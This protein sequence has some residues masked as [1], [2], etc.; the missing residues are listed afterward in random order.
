MSMLVSNP[1][2]EILPHFFSSGVH[3]RG[4]FYKVK[5][6]SFSIFFSDSCTEI[7]SSFYK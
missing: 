3:S 1:A 7:V 2:Y 4:D 5:F 6:Q